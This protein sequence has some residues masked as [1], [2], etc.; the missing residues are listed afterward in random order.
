MDWISR[1]NYEADPDPDLWENWRLGECIT[2]WESRRQ[3]QESLGHSRD[4]DGDVEM[5]WDYYHN[6]PER[7]EWEPSRRNSAGTQIQ[8]R[9]INR[10]RIR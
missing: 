8:T 6:D 7:S 5:G 3:Y 4:P 10:G 1:A 9:R 2:A